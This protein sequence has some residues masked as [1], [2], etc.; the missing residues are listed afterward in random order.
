M[1]RQASLPAVEGGILLPGKIVHRSK[2]LPFAL[3]FWVAH[4][5]RRAGSPG[6]TSAKMADATIYGQA[7][8]GS[9]GQELL[10]KK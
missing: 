10:S 1:W 9:G 8:T 6:S 4:K 7:L 2:R 3:T 5:F